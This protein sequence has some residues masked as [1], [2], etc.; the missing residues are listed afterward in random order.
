MFDATFLKWAVS[1]ALA[2]R[3]LISKD[4]WWKR[5]PSTVILIL[6]FGSIIAFDPVVKIL[7]L[8]PGTMMRG[9]SVLWY[10]GAVALLVWQFIS[11]DQ[12]VLRIISGTVAAL[13]LVPLVV[14][15]LTAMAFVLASI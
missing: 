4:S 1:L 15:A 9:I 5:V 6:L 13:Y 8:N 10:V 14:F 2:G 12:M 7:S 3:I 11:A